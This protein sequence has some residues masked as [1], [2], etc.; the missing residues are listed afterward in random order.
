MKQCVFALA[1]LLMGLTLVFQ[2]ACYFDN[3]E[4]LYGITPGTCDTTAI[5]YSAD[6]KPLIEANCTV[7]HSPS[8]VQSATPV[9]NHADLKILADNGKLVDR[10]NDAGSPMPQTGLLP[11][12]ERN[13]IR[14]WVNA[15]APNN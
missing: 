6:I 7:C 3:E 4:E 11:E 13:M 9:D 8:G 5:S 14:A 12:C 2:S 10:T 15:G 1:L